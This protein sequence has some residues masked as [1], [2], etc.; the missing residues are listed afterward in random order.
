[1][2]GCGKMGRVDDESRGPRARKPPGTS[3]SS[4]K[5]STRVRYF[6]GASLGT[7][8]TGVG[9]SKFRVVGHKE[10]GHGE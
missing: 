2:S 1:M 9:E 4:A 8:K 7:K 6:S 10:E 5:A 3:A